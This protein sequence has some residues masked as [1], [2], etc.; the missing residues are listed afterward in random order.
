MERYARSGGKVCFVGPAGTHDE[1]M[2]PRKQHAFDELLGPGIDRIG[3]TDSV[4]PAVRRLCGADVSLSLRAPSGVCAEL[5][6]QSG[7]RLVH[8][9]NY[10]TGAPARDIS[11]SVRLPVS[12]AVKNVVFAS[13]LQADDVRL[14]FEVRDHRVEF[15]V[16]SVDVYGIA[17]VTFE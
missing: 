5:T 13:P 8:L 15:T 9:V 1:W 17:V 10:Q 12:R 3:E 2:L 16:P 6:Q 14:A 11:V 7:R 4:M